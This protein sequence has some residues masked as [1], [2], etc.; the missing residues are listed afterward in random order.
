MTV[1]APSLA[2]NAEGSA[3]DTGRAYTNGR[4]EENRYSYGIS[5]IV[6]RVCAYTRLICHGYR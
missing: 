4:S 2:Q 6:G 3:A 5:I 1:S